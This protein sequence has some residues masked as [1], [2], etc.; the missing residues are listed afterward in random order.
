MAKLT[1]RTIDAIKPGERERFVWDGELRGFGVR[2]LPTGI[3][4]FLVQY[5]TGAKRQRRMVLGRYGVVS[6]E[7]ARRE[8]REALALVARGKDPAAEREKSREAGTIARLCERYLTEHAQAFKKASS[9]ATDRQLIEKNLKP[10]LGSTPVSEVT[11]ADVLKFRHTLRGS[12]IAAN[13]SLA[14]LS[15]MMNL[16]EAWGLR[17]DGSNPC[18]HVERFAENERRRF[19]SPEE[20]SVIGATLA[21]AERT[22]TAHPGVIAAI[23]LLS[24]TG[25][26]LSEILRLRWEDVDFQ[27]KCL[28]LPDAKAGARS[29]PLGSA[30]LA[31][32]VELEGKSAPYVI[33]GTRPGQPLSIWCMERGWQRLRE[34][35]GLTDA[36]IHDLRHTVATMAA[37]SGLN[38]FVV[39]DLLGHKTLA[40]ANRYV[41]RVTDPLQE[42]ADGLSTRVATMMA[43]TPT[44]A[45]VRRLRRA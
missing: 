30:A 15:K 43:S 19:Y 7:V 14:L 2:V 36:R 22:A 42:A 3:K 20:L 26:R 10:H 25:C 12:P 6:P 35:A 45:E 33:Q 4:T 16:A 24:L 21:D 18:R 8:A 17:P 9:V 5:R 34:K 39:R 1:I 32:L 44:T 28:R 27:A 38:A 41:K 11:R 31:L 23:R 40:M 13:R 37:A 29:V